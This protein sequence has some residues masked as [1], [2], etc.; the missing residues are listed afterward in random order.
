MGCQDA[1][2]SMDY[3]GSSDFYRAETRKAR[4][5]HRCCEC[6]EVINVGEVHQYVAGKSDGEFWE[7]RTCAACHE[8]RRVFVCGAHVL[9]T[10]WEEIG[11]QLFP[12][13]NEITAI[14]CLA[15]LT[16]QAAID[17]MRAKYADY[18]EH[19]S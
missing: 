14:D 12:E 8:I 18:Q 11:Y 15:R 5:P 6:R 13:W 3:E 10:L 16:T 4:K 1:C 2:V 9:E 7:D 17:K 19:Q